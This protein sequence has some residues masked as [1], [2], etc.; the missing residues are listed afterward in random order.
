MDPAIVMDELPQPYRM[1]VKLIEC[2]II[3]SV[4]LEVIRLHPELQQGT[5]GEPLAL[6]PNFALQKSCT[7][8]SVIEQ[9]FLA[10]SM[11]ESQGFLFMTASNDALVMVDP[12]SGAILQSLLM[13]QD[14]FTSLN[15]SS[16]S[17][18]I[19]ASPLWIAGIS[20]PITSDRVLRVIICNII[21]VEEAVVSLEAD[22]G[23]KATPKKGAAAEPEPM[24]IASKCRVSI[25][26]IRL[27][28]QVTSPTLI[29]MVVAYECLVAVAGKKLSDLRSMDIS[30]DA[31]LL[32]V[33]SSE[34]LVLFSLP[35]VEEKSE[36]NG[37]SMEHITEDD[38][39][40]E[41][42][43]K[44]E[45]LQP[46][47]VVGPDS[48][49][50]GNKTIRHL[51]LFPLTASLSL[52]AAQQAAQKPTHRQGQNT[53]YHTGICLIFEEK[54]EWT[55]LGLKGLKADQSGD[56]NR[57][58]AA[59]IS[60]WSLAA[61]VSAVTV[62]EGKSLIVLGLCDGSLSMWNIATRNF[63]SIVGK[64]ET[65]VTSL[66]IA[67]SESAEGRGEYNFYML[68]GAQDGTLC[69][70]TI[71][72]PRNNVDSF[73]AASM[74]DSAASFTPC[75][76]A[77][78]IAFR[79]DV[80]PGCSIV[81]IR[82]LVNLPLVVVQCSDGLCILYDLQGAALLGKFV[83]YSGIM[84]KQ[85]KWQVA[86]LDEIWR[87]SVADEGVAELKTVSS[88][89]RSSAPASVLQRAPKYSISP[90]SS[91]CG[92]PGL[93]SVSTSSSRGYH[94]IYFRNESPVLALFRLEDLFVAFFPGLVSACS[95]GGGVGRMLQM[96]YK[97]SS[98]ERLD[99]TLA[100]TRLLNFDR[101][102]DALLHVPSTRQSTGKGKDRGGTGSKTAP[103][104]GSETNRHRNSR[105]G[106]GGE[107]TIE[108][109]HTKFSAD[110]ETL[111][112]IT[113]DR[114]A[115]SGLAATKNARKSQEQ[116]Q[117]RKQRLQNQLSELSNAFAN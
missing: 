56:Q 115:E 7:P 70:F 51:V 89:E 2:E 60:Q 4:W 33:A 85:I 101:M 34:G 42:E 54:T 62:D 114:V 90:S 77:S 52:P 117:V 98:A 72:V 65:A 27:G 25:V 69:F 96:F 102:A 74:N 84:S 71:N 95:Q 5:D 104:R 108:P 91:L 19:R 1:I 53:F 87:A 23:K 30:L 109:A 17:N 37:I 94:S 88:A 39:E 48:T 63:T 38:G 49:L 20:R 61:A 99:A 29:K 9:P 43:H 97:L 26:E 103:R 35:K 75:L 41:I 105:T 28:E 116:R 80:C 11:V 50:L 16:S 57:V 81:S 68:S 31:E 59:V 73:Y 100:S 13:K 36:K 86:T 113:W 55:M 67:R 111:S 21:D 10:T 107:C 22:A 110:A 40:E 24:K 82:S 32:G 8:S 66:C 76:S 112:K 106:L 3:D 18:P 12:S 58:T 44:A 78:F 15:I 45:L 79:F 14:D 6:L 92:L 83:L 46:C 64:H 47:L 93:N